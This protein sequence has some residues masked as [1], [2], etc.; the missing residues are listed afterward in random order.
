MLIPILVEQKLRMRVV[1]VA[2]KDDDTAKYIND[3]LESLGLLAL[4]GE[5]R[6]W[7]EW[8]TNRSWAPPLFN[9]VFESRYRWG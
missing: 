4:Y 5:K 9:A 6:V 8:S 1:N 7:L 2:M 3:W